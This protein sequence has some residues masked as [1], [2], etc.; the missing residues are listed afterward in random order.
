MREERPGTAPSLDLRSLRSSRRAVVVV[1]LAVAVLLVAPAAAAYDTPTR[2]NEVA[3]VYSLGVGEVRCPSEAEWGADPYST[4]FGWGYTNVRRDTI[5]LYDYWI[6]AARVATLGG[7][8][9][10]TPTGS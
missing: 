9:G 1:V 2:L 4:S 10:R 5:M 8:R 3:H 7:L 6:I